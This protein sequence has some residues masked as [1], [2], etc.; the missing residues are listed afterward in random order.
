MTD[1]EDLKKRYADKIAQ[2][3][4][5]DPQAFL[6]LDRPSERRGRPVKEKS[7]ITLRY[8]RL[9]HVPEQSETQKAFWA[10]ASDGFTFG[11]GD[12][13]AAGLAAFPAWFD[14]RDAAQ[15]YEDE[16]NRARAEADYLQERH[17]IAYGAGA[18]VGNVA[19]PVNYTPAGWVGRA[20]NAGKAANFLTK[21]M[22]L[23][24]VGAVDGAIYG[25]NGGTGGVGN[26][27]HDAAKG[28]VIGA[29]I[30]GSLPGAGQLAAKAGGP[31]LDAL[32]MPVI[33]R[34]TQ[35]PQQA[36]ILLDKARTLRLRDPNAWQADLPY[37]LK[38]FYDTTFGKGRMTSDDLIIL[39][40]G[41]FN[42]GKTNAEIVTTTDRVNKI[43]K[44]YV[45]AGYKKDPI[46][47]KGLLSA[48]EKFRYREPAKK[49]WPHP[50][51]KSNV[52]ANLE[53][54]LKRIKGSRRNF[55]H[56]L[57]VDIVD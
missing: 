46:G 57:H 5:D 45:G 44:T 49:R 13:M 20:A 32:A 41:L 16:V 26:R 38:T 27:L 30:A 50:S 35:D 24:K 47:D 42:E 21:S 29:T 8:G 25:F 55:R 56:N 9:G 4:R 11:A 51:A 6:D 17:P 36:A 23:A 53:R 28:A 18:I 52:Q 7:K 43:G 54:D 40:R 14:E 12:E 19:Q 39:Q 31:V 3:I 22:N 1:Y 2:R 34:I 37:V 10:G 33:R 15:V 48:D